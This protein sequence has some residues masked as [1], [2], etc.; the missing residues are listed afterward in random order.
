M[1]GKAPLAIPAAPDA[2]KN[3]KITSPLAN[4]ASA[5]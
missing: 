2:P 5:G 4:M 3:Q 1:V